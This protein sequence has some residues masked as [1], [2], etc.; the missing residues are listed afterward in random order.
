MGE[1]F[2][3]EYFERNILEEMFWEDFLGEILCL[4]CQLS[5]LNME[6][7]DMFVKILDFVK[8]LYK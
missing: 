2:L 4:H 7:I 3:G 5:Y 1:I 8:I 6:R